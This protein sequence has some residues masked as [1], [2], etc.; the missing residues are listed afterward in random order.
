MSQSVPELNKIA[1]NKLGI[2]FK[3][4]DRNDNSRWLLFAHA[5]CEELLELTSHSARS[6]LILFRN[7]VHPEDRESYEQS[8]ID[9]AANLQPWI[10][11]VG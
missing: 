10:W 6:N 3:L 11:K 8:L 5:S 7:L 1:A 9:S 2:I 4:I